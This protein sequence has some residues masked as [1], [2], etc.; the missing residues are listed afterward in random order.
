MLAE[1]RGEIP[2]A[3]R[4]RGRRDR[5]AGEEALDVGDGLGQRGVLVTDRRDELAAQR[6]TP[7][8][9]GECSV[10]RRVG[11]DVNRLGGDD[12][13]AWHPLD[14]LGERHA[15]RTRPREPLAKRG[16]PWTVQRI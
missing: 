15:T 5:T 13:V 2:R 7:A 9:D 14:L 3:P 16:V 4:S 12:A 11:A 1:S 8:G 10:L 6:G